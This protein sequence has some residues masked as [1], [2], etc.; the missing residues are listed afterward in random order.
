MLGAMCVVDLPSAIAAVSV[1]D[2]STP[3]DGLRLLQQCRQIGMWGQWLSQRQ[4]MNA[5]T[6]PPQHLSSCLSIL[7]QERNSCVNASASDILEAVRRQH[8]ASLW[9]RSAVFTISAWNNWAVVQAFFESLLT[10]NPWLERAVW[11]IA[12]RSDHPD[13]ACKEILA[14]FAALRKRHTSTFIQVLSLE[15]VAHYMPFSPMELAFRYALKT[16]NTAIKPHV[17]QYLFRMGSDYV[18]Y[19]DPDVHFYS[20][21]DEVAL[22]L[23]RRGVVITPHILR[24]YPNDGKWQTDLQILRVGVFNF[25][26]V[27]F[28]LRAYADPVQRFLS[29][30]GARLRFQGGVNLERGIHFDQGWSV[31]IPSFLPQGA[32]EVLTDPRYNVA[33][34]NLHYRG[35]HIDFNDGN[36]T[37]DQ[38]PLV[39]YHFSGIATDTFSAGGLSPHQ[40][41]YSLSDFPNLKPLF[42]QYVSSIQSD[43]S[44][45]R[46]IV[47]GYD[48]YDN[49]LSIAPWQRAL[50]FMTSP[51]G[52]ATSVGPSQPAPEFAAKLL[53]LHESPFSVDSGQVSKETF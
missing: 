22:L 2:S 31:F 26:F 8:G 49:G 53:R 6:C 32:Y 33:Y 28:S 45:Y 44:H 17:F 41:R 4:L 52:R 37:Y 3:V 50:F 34:W 48:F 5:S 1:D 12:D 14:A 30:W 40:T 46:R 10:H 43:N 20:D 21:L 51:D 15:E 35:V 18:L 38:A 13:P 29:W 9:R 36:A 16:F 27:A 24:E 7:K 42:D 39:F 19:F 23:Q 25:G 11:F 47:Y